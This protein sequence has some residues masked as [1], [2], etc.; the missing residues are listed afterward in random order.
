MA[1]HTA[2]SGTGQRCELT[3]S[4][5]VAR[6]VVAAMR[7]RFG[8]VSPPARVN[9][10]DATVLTVDVTDQA[11]VRALMLMLWDSGHDVLAMTVAVDSRGA[12][13]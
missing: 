11:A 13:S 4:G 2:G 1:V 9:G 5:P 3:V 7:A 10:T 12:R 8:A 6:S